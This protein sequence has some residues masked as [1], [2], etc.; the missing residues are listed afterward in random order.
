MRKIKMKKETMGKLM[1]L[2]S[3]LIWGSSFVIMKNAVD[4]ITP[5]VLLSI[6]FILGTIFMSILF[7]NKVKYIKKEDLKGGF[8][9]GL[10]LFCA[11]TIQT[12]GLQLT[13]PGKN[14]FLTA[15][16]C[17]IVPF[18][19]WIW[20]KKRPDKFQWLAAILCFIGVGLV[21]L[22]SSLRMN[23][24]DLYTL[25]GGFLYAMHILIC[26]KAMQKTS[27][28]IVTTLQFAFAAVFSIISALLF[29]D[30]SIVTQI[31]GDIILQ[32]LY[33]AFFATTICYLFQNS[34]QK[35]VNEN[36]AAL[37]LS[38]ESVFGVFFSILLKE[39]TLNLQ[40]ILGFIV[41]F[42]AVIISETKLS[43]LKRGK[44]EC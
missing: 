16:Y 8:F 18:L 7:F 6:R 3:A 38:L 14:A 1:L 21:S 29:E 31:R 15:V 23:L 41:I 4:F 34:G 32:I 26:E 42:I 28:I 27:P 17:T 12:Y 36:T 39:E 20:L 25:I 9:A 44:K 24:G 30:I 33:L 11:F 43:F 37:L 13:T 2:S 10:A 35:L 22:D 40:I 19:S 5:H